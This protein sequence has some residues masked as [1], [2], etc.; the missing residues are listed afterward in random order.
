MLSVICGKEKRR[1]NKMDG[2]GVLLMVVRIGS[3]SKK[4]LSEKEVKTSKS[5]ETGTAHSGTH[6]KIFNWSG[7]KLD[8]YI[9]VGH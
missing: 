5:E 9:G 6:L 8:V 1:K 7:D 2:A 4:F 3:A